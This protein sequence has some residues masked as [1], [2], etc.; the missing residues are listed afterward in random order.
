MAKFRPD[1][2]TSARRLDQIIPP[3]RR[4]V[5]PRITRPLCTEIV[6]IEEIAAQ[7][8]EPRQRSILVH[9]CQSTASDNVGREDCR[10]FPFLDLAPRPCILHNGAA[11]AAPAVGPHLRLRK[12]LPSNG[13]TAL[14]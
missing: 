2:H 7:S 3:M 5:A 6:G 4:S 13:R 1:P 11:D 10:Q 9:A 8:S 12:R 14:G